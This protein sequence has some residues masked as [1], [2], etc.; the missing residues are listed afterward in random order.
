MEIDATDIEGRPLKATG[1]VESRFVLLHPRG[2]CICSAVRWIV[3]GKEAY[4]EDQD[5]W[6]LDQWHS[7]REAL[8]RR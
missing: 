2:I 4:G 1:T 3:N 5:V 7:A 8:A 6:R